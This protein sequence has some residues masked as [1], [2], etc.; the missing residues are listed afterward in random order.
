MGQAI[1]DFALGKN[2]ATT[3]GGYN[4]V[5]IRDLSQTIINSLNV[6]KRGEIYLISGSYITINEIAQLA[7]PDKKLPVISL[8]LLILFLPI[9]TLLKKLFNVNLPI[10]KETLITLKTA[11]KNM[12]CSKAIKDL[13]HNNRPIEDTFNDLKLWYNTKFKL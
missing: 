1:L 9:I 12:D 10:T 5:D 2:P 3:T 8:N 11:P 13:G 6:N 7:N 4:L